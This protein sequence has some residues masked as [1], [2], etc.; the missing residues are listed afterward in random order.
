MP[1][2]PNVIK[3]ILDKLNF[4]DNQQKISLTNVT[5]AVFVIITAIRS[6][7]GGSSID[8]HLFKWQIQQCDTAAT[9]P[10]LFSL[11]NYSHKRHVNDKA[12]RSNNDQQ[13]SNPN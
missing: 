2:I 6:A 9:L 5:V 8:L 13:D 12:N 1:N 4:L 7:F 11:L 3:S 10:V